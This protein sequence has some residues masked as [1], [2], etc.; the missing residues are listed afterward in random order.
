[1]QTWFVM[2]YLL[3]RERQSDAAATEKKI[4]PCNDCKVFLY[5]RRGLESL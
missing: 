3:D 1:M 4:N 5:E 2:T